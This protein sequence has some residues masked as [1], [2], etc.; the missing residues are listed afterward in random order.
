MGRG[1]SALQQD[2]WYSLV[3]VKT[4]LR[5]DKV[6]GSS[7]GGP[8]KS[9]HSGRAS[10][11]ASRAVSSTPTSSP[12][13]LKCSRTCCQCQEIPPRGLATIISKTL[14]TWACSHH[15]LSNCGQSEAPTVECYPRRD[16]NAHVNGTPL[17]WLALM[18]D[19]SPKAPHP[20]IP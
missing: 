13:R 7:R 11:T 3:N 9:G 1:G 8:Q 10:T 15:F 17:A 12:V 5:V 19:P 20:H 4:A 14:L 2:Q 6:A 16:T 18:Q